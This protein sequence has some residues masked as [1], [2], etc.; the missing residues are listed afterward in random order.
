MKIKC[1]CIDDEPLALKQLAG[2]I[3]KIPFLE[4]VAECDSAAEAGE[5]LADNEIELMFVDIN[6]PDMS[7]ME[8]VKSLTEKP[9][10]IFTT[11][12]DEY[13]VEGFVVEA[14]DYLLKPFGFDR[15]QTSA[16][17]VKRLIELKSQAPEIVQ[18]NKEHLFVKS[19]YRLLRIE[20]SDIKYIESMHE[21]V[22]IHLTTGKPVMTMI[23]LKSLEEQL[24]K[25]SFMRVHRS[26]I[27]N[28][29]KISVIERSR[30]VFDGK[31]YIPISDQYKAKF[32]EYIDKYFLS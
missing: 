21:Y 5:I 7:G 31:V 11:A 19:E 12:Y 6:M 27:V 2:Y 15:F 16:T 29:A 32:Q 17:K 10:I 8:F 18:S 23:S 30:I 26:Y 4:L 22:S 9:Y 1:I 14:V 25:D 20:L 24:P 13:A 3:K 28:L